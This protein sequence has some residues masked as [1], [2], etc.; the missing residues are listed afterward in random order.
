MASLLGFLKGAA[1]QVNPLDNGATYKN[2]KPTNNQASSAQQLLNY[3]KG[4]VHPF[5][6]FGSAVI[7]TPQMIAADVSNNPTAQAHTQK[8]VFGTT[9]TNSIRNQIIGDTLQTALLAGAP[10]IGRGAASIATSLAPNAATEGAL[11]ALSR[12]GSLGDS[13]A[14]RLLAGTAL[15]TPLSATLPAGLAAA[16]GANQVINTGFGLAG[17]KAVGQKLSL[18]KAT[19]QAIPQTL[20][21]IGAEGLSAIHEHAPTVASKITSA[22]QSNNKL[23]LDQRGSVRL[24][25]TAGKGAPFD[26]KNPLGAKTKPLDVS[27]PLDATIK[28]PLR[29]KA[30]VPVK[31]LSGAAQQS[32]LAKLKAPFKDEIGAVGSGVGK[33][34]EQMDGQNLPD[35]SPNGSIDP[36]IT[37]RMMKDYVEGRPLPGEKSVAEQKVPNTLNTDEGKVFYH[38]TNNADL[39]SLT[40]LK[41]GRDIGKSSTNMTY[42]TENPEIAKNFGSNVISGKVYGKH[43]DISKLGNNA[44]DPVKVPKDF[45]DYTTNKLLSP[46]DRRVFEQQYLRGGG[47]NRIIDATPDIQKYL[48]SKGYS[49]VTVPRVGSDVSGARSE[50]VIINKD[51]LTRPA[52]VPTIKTTTGKT[53]TEADFNKMIPAEPGVKTSSAKL[54]DVNKMTPDELMNLSPKDQMALAKQNGIIKDT[55]LAPP[56]VNTALNPHKSIVQEV[57]PGDYGAAISNSQ[58]VS[59]PIDVARGLWEHAMG[60]LAPE[61]KANFWRLAEKPN[62]PSY[63]PQLNE[64]IGRWRQADNMV[65]ANSQALG[66]N[67]NYLTDHA[68]HPWQLP[69]EY[70]QHVINGGSPTD[71]KGLNNFSRK[72][73]TIA[74]GEAKGLT[75]GTDPVKEGS[76]YLGANST[77]LRKVALKQGLGLADSGAE[78]HPLTRDLGNGHTVQMSREGFKATKGVAYDPASANPVIK[79]AR[80]LNRFTKGTL[81]SLGQFHP[82]NIG[83]RASGTLLSE[84]HPIAAA[85]GLYGVFRA[86]FGTEYADNAIGNAVKDGTVERAA[87]IGMPYGAPH[88]GAIVGQGIG[89]HTVFN[90][91][92]PVLHDQVARSIIS[93]LEKKNIPLD[94]SQAR[95]AGAAGARIMGEMNNE[96]MNISPQL[97]RTMGDFLLANKYTSSKFAQLGHAAEGGLA[98][99]YARRNIASNVIA[100]TAIIAGVGA[101]AGQK[102]DNIRDTLL[103]GLVDPAIP[104]PMKDKK[105]NTVKLRL[106]GTDTSDLAKLVGIKLVRQNDGHLGVSWSPK[107][108]PSTV[109]D[110]ARSR[111]AP[112]ASTAVKVGTNTSYAGKPLFDPNAPAGVKAQQIGTSVT[113]GLLPIGLQGLPNTNVVEKHL[114]QGVRQVLNASAPGGNPLVKSVGSSFGV[115]PTTDMTTGKGLDTS[116]YFDALS[117]AKDGLNRQEKDALDLYSGSKKNPV[118]GAYDVLPTVDDQRSKATTLLQNPKVIDSLITMNQKLSGQGQKVDPLWQQSKGNITKYLQYQAMPPGGADRAHWITQN[119]SWYTPLSNSRSTFFNSLPPG[120]PNK[121][122]QPIEYPNATPQIAQKQSTFFGLPDAA[123]RASYIA[124]NPDLQ[125]QLDKQV[126]YNNQMR[127]AQGYGQLDTYPT[128]SP[129]VQKIID[130][131]NAIPKGGGSKG[132]NLYRSQWIQAHPQEYA[133]MSQYFTQASV[134]SLE[135]DAGQAQFK[136]TGLSQTGLKD[137]SNLGQYDV[138]KQTDANG[139]T[140][141]SLGGNSSGSSGYSSYSK[142]SSGSTRSPGYAS[143]KTASSLKAP[144]ITGVKVKKL[145]A[146]KAPTTRKLA[147]S[148]IPK[149]KSSASTRKL[150]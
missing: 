15:R 45:V 49:T 98:G 77:I 51:A 65:H 6:T 129:A 84:G 44:F 88:E 124:S 68:L 80:G 102:S 122:A 11:T 123:S 101:L 62:D 57:K 39:K 89:S 23:A 37:T 118:T 36:A 104:T 135:K 58:V 133:A 121:P 128:A 64:A 52:E 127:Q 28:T 117:Q 9:D 71:F 85:K 130:T 43:L 116:R 27:N 3:G 115:T 69:E 78:T 67:T 125:Q 144:K 100:T 70:T 30:N 21:G 24:P 18:G 29:V 72:Y 87:K 96:T 132:G 48:V 56:E 60:K 7:H 149:I 113:Q 73:R 111:L 90:K 13:S 55:P 138:G 12:A 4:F 91:Q 2:A 107:N 34:R 17:Q 136:D 97:S 143:F 22:L 47:D 26:I 25:F 86:A 92:M 31:N 33:L 120:D 142:S 32:F 83:V 146:I 99:S 61:E 110:F 108:M 76:N 16:A 40:D 93:D 35:S 148:K 103:R 126:D 141:Y 1:R 109:T 20:L 53:I 5:S 54:P 19:K 150:A 75:L 119:S 10:A 105:G 131:Y 42:I 81:L 94:S 79:G 41:A 59:K 63:S 145:A 106:P 134:Y 95:A 66:G 140:F 139:N 46:R 14:S 8:N 74:E 147:V 38:G 114:P 112:W 82:I 50:T 137:I